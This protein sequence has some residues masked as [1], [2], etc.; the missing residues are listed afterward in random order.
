MESKTSL[1]RVAG[2]DWATTDTK[3]ALVEI[4][5]DRETGRLRVERSARSSAWSTLRR[6]CEVT[7]CLSLESTRTRLT[8]SWR[9]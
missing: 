2:I 4:C 5:L 6:Q 7:P 8:P 3:R 9:P 1:I